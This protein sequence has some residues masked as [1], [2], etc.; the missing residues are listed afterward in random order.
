MWDIALISGMADGVSL[1]VGNVKKSQNLYVGVLISLW[2]F[3]YA[4]QPKETFFDGLKKLDRR[5]HKCV[6]LR[7][8]YV[9]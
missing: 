1:L 4:A 8:E 2:L 5:S 9:E 7:R 6:K 3:L